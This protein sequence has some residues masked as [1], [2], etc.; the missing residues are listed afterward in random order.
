[1]VR[2]RAIRVVDPTEPAPPSGDYDASGLAPRKRSLSTRFGFLF[3]ANEKTA[4]FLVKKKLAR[5]AC[6]G[7]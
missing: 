3:C 6:A 4:A 5:S 7:C 1:V 2:A